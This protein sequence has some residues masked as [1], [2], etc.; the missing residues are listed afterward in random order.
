MA[1]LL[2]SFA[3]I[4]LSQDAPVTPEA[5]K[6]VDEA[7]QS[8]TPVYV[9]PVTA[10]QIGQLNAQG[11]LVMAVAPQD[12][13]A[14]LLKVPGMALT[15]LTPEILIA[16]SFLPGTPPQDLA[17]RVLAATARSLRLQLVTRDRALLD[18]AAQGHIQAIA[19]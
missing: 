3:A 16:A 18:Y 15:A 19:C 4:W 7:A 9:S 11:H 17:G 1:L 13:F 12:W 2:D 8:G 6:A 10:W 14:A 5:A